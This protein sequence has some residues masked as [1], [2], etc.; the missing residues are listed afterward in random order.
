[1][2]RSGAISGIGNVLGQTQEQ[3]DQGADRLQR[4][5]EFNANFFLGIQN[6][7]LNV[8]QLQEQKREHDQ[9][10]QYARDQ[11]AQLDMS[12][13]R[14][15][16]SREGLERLSRDLQVT[17]QEDRQ[18]HEVAESE[19]ERIKET[20]LQQMRDAVDYSRIRLERDRFDA[21]QDSDAMKRMVALAAGR[22]TNPETHR[23]MS[24]DEFVEY[25]RAK[26]GIDLSAPGAFDSYMNQLY[27]DDV[28]SI[29]DSFP[30]IANR[31][32]PF[33]MRE[34]YQ[35]AWTGDQAA[36]GQLQNDIALES[37]RQSAKAPLDGLESFN[38]Y[39]SVGGGAIPVADKDGKLVVNT[40]NPVGESVDKA[41]DAAIVAFGNRPPERRTAE[42]F[43]AGLRDAL[44]SVGIEYDDLPVQDI[45]ALEHVLAKKMR[46][47]KPTQLATGVAP[48]TR[49]AIWRYY[50]IE[51]KPAPTAEG[52]TRQ[53]VDAA[54]E[55]SRSELEYFDKRM[56]PIKVR[57][58]AHMKELT[59]REFMERKSPEE[60]ESIRR[61][62][63]E[64][65]MDS[66]RVSPLNDSQ[67]EAK[68]EIVKNFVHEYMQQ[69]GALPD[70]LMGSA[71][72]ELPHREAAGI[73]DP[74]PLKARN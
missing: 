23:V 3:L 48:G 26:Q 17:L 49:E 56:E 15:I 27:A 42:E 14:D 46:R 57:F 69:F 40:E 59:K 37:A 73:R 6:I 32:T 25:V 38:H 68:Q 22:M 61:R 11:L 35:Y 62:M 5:R 72:E 18:M 7:R 74:P 30:H 10:M 43:M 39:V 29:R 44:G 19:K 45:L 28:A 51:E 16:T 9:R 12:Q 70:G 65:I 52:V 21:D 71:E 58:N 36:L 20:K 47:D 66:L 64:I 50:S 33:R 54:Q 13:I 8:A 31:I 34:A 63:S 41:I 24:H 53:I 1:M 67:K 4:I 2:P 60:V 55:Q